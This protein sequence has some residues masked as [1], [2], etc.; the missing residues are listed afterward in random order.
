MSLT[1]LDT[2]SRSGA[3]RAFGFFS[4]F[5]IYFSFFLIA[6]K[7]DQNGFR[8]WSPC[9]ELNHEAR[10]SELI[11]DELKIGCEIQIVGESTREEWSGEH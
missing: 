6:N 3:A 11:D 5:S 9:K 10:V 2:N 7:A 4:L 1:T 8:V